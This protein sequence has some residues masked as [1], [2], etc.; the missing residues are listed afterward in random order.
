MDCSAFFTDPYGLCNVDDVAKSSVGVRIDPGQNFQ[1]KSN[2]GL[3]S[4]PLFFIFSQGDKLHKE[5][6]NLII[7]VIFLCF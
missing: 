2:I 6:L 1:F 3:Y 7:Q 5:M 4:K